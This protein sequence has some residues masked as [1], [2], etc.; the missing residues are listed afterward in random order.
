MNAV[1]HSREGDRLE[2]PRH[3]KEPRLLLPQVLHDLFLRRASE[4]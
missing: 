3:V 2:T 4:H 1:A